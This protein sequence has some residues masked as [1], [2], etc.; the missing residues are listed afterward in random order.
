M[1]SLVTLVRPVLT[2]MVC[3]I[4]SVVQRLGAGSPRAQRS[5]TPAR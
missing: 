2:P 3:N 4:S 1:L 5:D